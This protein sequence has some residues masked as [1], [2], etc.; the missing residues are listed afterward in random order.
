MSR[1]S[2][3]QIIALSP[4]VKSCSRVIV[5]SGKQTTTSISP[6]ARPPGRLA[7]S[8]GESFRTHPAFYWLAGARRSDRILSV[9]LSKYVGGPVAVPAV[10][11]CQIVVMMAHGT[12]MG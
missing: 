12:H 10:V 7:V 4:D 2:T 5:V 1:S 8:A 3:T 9:R 6:R 11:A